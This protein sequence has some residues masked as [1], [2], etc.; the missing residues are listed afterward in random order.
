MKIDLARYVSLLGSIKER[1]HLAQTR[2][3]LSANRQMLE[4]YWDIGRLILAQQ[5]IEGWGS[6][7]IPRLSR[8]LRSEMPEL[9]GFSERITI[10]QERMGGVACMRGLR[11]PVAT[12]VGMIAE[13]MT[14]AEVLDDYPD[15][16]A[17]D[18]R[19]ALRYAAAALRE[20][21]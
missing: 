5:A 14:E 11:I 21:S 3:M 18:I 9:K 4:M 13:G 8:D 2:A 6:A 7:V 19:E 17:E 16:Q 1:V 15:L 20:R 12:V 10:D